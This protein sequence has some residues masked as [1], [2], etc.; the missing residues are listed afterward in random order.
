MSRPAR[1]WYGSWTLVA[2][3]SAAVAVLG[4][5]PLFLADQL[6]VAAGCTNAAASC[7]IPSWVTPLE[8]LAWAGAMIAAA[9]AVT[10]A[11]RAAR[12]GDRSSLARLAIL[13]AIAVAATLVL[14]TLHW[15]TGDAMLV[16]PPD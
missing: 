9:L 12:S 5:T 8:W 7:R 3:V 4:F 11:A 1:P 15:N 2:S 6:V 16:P 14:L 13:A 10:A